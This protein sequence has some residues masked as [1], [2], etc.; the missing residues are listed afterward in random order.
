M[1][2]DFFNIDIPNGIDEMI[3]RSENDGSAFFH[4]STRSHF[5]CRPLEFYPLDKP[6]DEGCNRLLIGYYAETIREPDSGD[7]FGRVRPVFFN[8]SVRADD[9]QEKAHLTMG[10]PLGDL[11]N[12]ARAAR[13]LAMRYRDEAKNTGVIPDHTRGK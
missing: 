5:G 11:L 4:K 7:R 12:D 1:P 13:K 8:L 6:L 2:R 10:S 3:R 9:K